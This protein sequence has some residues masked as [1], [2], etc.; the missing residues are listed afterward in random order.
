MED[1]KKSVELLLEKATE[2]GKTSFELVKLKVLDKTSDVVSTFIPHSV[3]I[4]L[5]GSFTLFLNLGLAFW[6]GEILGKTF[7][8][9]FVVAGFYVITGIVVH[10]FMHKWLKKVVGNYFIKQVLK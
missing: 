1:N 5:I 3:V 6:L 2:Y 7:Y 8:G 9:F 10:F 4:V